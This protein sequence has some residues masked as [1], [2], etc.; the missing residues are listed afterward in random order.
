M[1]LWSLSS[2]QLNTFVYFFNFFVP[3]D[4]SISFSNPLSTCVFPQPIVRRKQWDLTIGTLAWTALSRPQSGAPAL[5]PA[6]WGCPLGSLIRIA[7]VRWWSRADCVWSDPV[8]TS[9]TRRSSHSLHQRY[10]LDAIFQ[11]RRFGF[12]ISGG[13]IITV[14]S[15]GPP[16]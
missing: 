13:H 11:G 5:K 6:A 8:T 4:V 1:V 3:D 15:R 2:F 7:G 12:N 14:G 16:P 10:F 9:R